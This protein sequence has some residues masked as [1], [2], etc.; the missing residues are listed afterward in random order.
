MKSRVRG[1]LELYDRFGEITLW[2]KK[3]DTKEVGKIFKINTLSAVTLSYARQTVRTLSR[4]WS[5]EG[6]ASAKCRI[7]PACH[8]VRHCGGKGKN[9]LIFSEHSNFFPVQSDFEFLC[10]KMQSLL[11]CCIQTY[12]LVQW[13]SFAYL[14]LFSTL[15][16][17]LGQLAKWLLSKTLKWN[18]VTN[19]TLWAKIISVKNMHM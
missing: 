2:K 9:K 1:S 3:R 7:C 19:Q 11:F 12:S 10:Y 18:W 5:I 13:L 14:S 6:F 8:Q 16:P 17:L 15:R 4:I